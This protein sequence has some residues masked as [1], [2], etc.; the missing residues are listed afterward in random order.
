MTGQLIF[1]DPKPATTSYD[2]TNQK[3]LPSSIVGRVGI[4]IY[5]TIG[6]NPIWLLQFWFAPNREQVP[7]QERVED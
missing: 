7:L 4:K 3:V 1:S 2:S 6:Y 5:L